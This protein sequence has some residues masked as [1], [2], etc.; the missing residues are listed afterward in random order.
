MNIM[1]TLLKNVKQKVHVKIIT[2]KIITTIKLAFAL[3]VKFGMDIIVQSLNLVSQISIG[4][5]INA[6]LLKFVSPDI[7]GMLSN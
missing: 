2:F 4:M 1:I 3:M 6:F 5:D 7:S